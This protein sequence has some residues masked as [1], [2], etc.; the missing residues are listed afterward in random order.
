MN[1]PFNTTFQSTIAYGLS[2]NITKENRHQVHKR[3]LCISEITKLQH[4]SNLR[5]NLQT[6]KIAMLSSSVY[7]SQYNV[8]ATSWDKKNIVTELV[9]LT[10]NPVVQG[11]FTGTLSGYTIS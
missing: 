1:K 6:P 2:N 4:K 5:I 10:L 11:V 8:G 3:V 7:C 9:L